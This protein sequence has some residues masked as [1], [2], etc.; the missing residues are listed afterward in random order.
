MMGLL[1]NMPGA[2]I[3]TEL[4]SSFD[5]V[6]PDGLVMLP[7][8]PLGGVYVESYRTVTQVYELVYAPVFMDGSFR[9]YDRPGF[10]FYQLYNTEA[11][12]RFEEFL[13]GWGTYLKNKPAKPLKSPVFM[14][15]FPDE[16]DRF[17]F[18]FSDRDA[19]NISQAGQSY[20]YET[21]AEAG[22]P[23]GFSTNLEGVL[24]LDD[25]MSDICILPSLKNASDAVKQ[26][27][28]ALSGEG[29]ALIAV[30]MNA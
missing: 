20:I 17:D 16:D 25:S 10:Q 14:A 9:Y 22:I 7:T 5:P 19:N 4:Y 2:N 28:R 21:L 1:L 27:L 18:D 23:K 8:P 29:V 12:Q 3:V 13:K 30:P 15:E 6:C 26:K 11:S 24:D